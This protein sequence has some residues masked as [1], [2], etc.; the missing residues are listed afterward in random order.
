MPYHLFP[1]SL[2]IFI[3]FSLVRSIKEDNDKINDELLRRLRRETNTLPVQESI[4]S[5]N[6]SRSTL[7][8]GLS[9]D[10]LKA[11]LIHLIEVSWILRFLT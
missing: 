10:Q 6:V 3:H 1:S 4:S 2:L 8:E 11:A 7:V 9:R 5:A